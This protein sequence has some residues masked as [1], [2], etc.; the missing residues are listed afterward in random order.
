M[1]QVLDNIATYWILGDVL[2]VL[3][4]MVMVTLMIVDKHLSNHSNELHFDDVLC[5]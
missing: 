1:L 2:C 3:V 4:T 5:C